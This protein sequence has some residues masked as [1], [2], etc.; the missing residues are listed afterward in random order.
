MMLGA[1]A[2]FSPWWAG[3]WSLAV[4]GLLAIAAA[5]FELVG[6][7]ALRDGGT[8]ERRY[9][10]SVVLLVAGLLLFLS[11]AF[12]LRALLVV[13]AVLLVADGVVK[14]AS[15][16]RR[17]T[18][19]R[20][21]QVV[22]GL[23][24]IALGAFLFSYRFSLG[25]LAVGLVVGLWMISAGWTMAFEQAALEPGTASE[26]DPGLRLGLGPETGL[27]ARASEAL[28]REVDRQNVDF[29]WCAT[30]AATFFAIHIGRM[31]LQFSKFGIISV[32]IAVL[33]D[34][35][36]AV[37]LAVVVILP[38]RLFVRR[39]ARGIERSAWQRRLSDSS[40]SQ[41]LALGD[42]L[43]NYWLDYR[44]RFDARLFTMR[45]SFK[46]ALFR[47]VQIGLP[48][49][50]LLVAVNPLWGI[51]WFFNTEDWVTGFWQTLVEA[52]IDPWRETMIDAV[53][54]SQGA[55]SPATPGL[56]EIRPPGVADATDF[57]FV[58]IG[59]TGEGDDSQLV[60]KD[61]L[62]L[63]GQRDEVKFLVVSSDVIYPAGAMKDYEPNFYLP[64]KGF[65]KPIYAIPGNHDWYMGNA[66]FT[67][68][69]FEVDA[70]RAALRAQIAGDPVLRGRFDERTDWMIAE[71]ERLRGE[72]RVQTGGQRAPFF[73]IHGRDF[74]LITVD[75]GISKR[76]DDKEKAW[77]EAALERS[78]GTFTLVN[79]GHPFYAGGYDQ[80]RFTPSFAAISDI[81][82][83]YDV[84]VVVAGDTHDF[85]YYRET[86]GTKTTHNFVTGGGGAYLSI[87][88]A[89]DW[90]AQPPVADWAYYP[91]A[92]AL[93]HKLDME[94]S[95]W[96]RP[97]WW[98]AKWAGGWPSSVEMLSG[99]FDFNRAPFYQS[100]LEVNVEGSRNQVRIV[101]Q[102]VNG[103]LTW[104]DL[105]R[106]GNI[107]PANRTLDDAVE[108][109]FP[110]HADSA[111]QNNVRP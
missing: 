67:A 73:E 20:V 83:R 95:G 68:N 13:L 45:Q 63:E 59:D 32:T 60:L 15:I 99:A 19:S 22:N 84:P 77:L 105:D 42:R 79:L 10:E 86:S 33:G 4:L 104:R 48:A 81:L 27:K 93:R 36:I 14:L 106:G 43:A 12:V 107:V 1:V 85:E 26:F 111:G 75:T 53:A 57:S 16:A 3:E 11:P 91:S 110:L 82:A 89:L 9:V 88:T 17:G 98:W 2:L 100:F 54:A 5:V 51:S 58:I 78:R 7:R 94:T 101:L 39:V 71:A 70:A 44:L 41:T 30:L 37:V 49:T 65:E 72:Y 80:R 96:K 64:F 76:I 69:F 6:V 25:S 24:H 35:V 31:D 66:A 87:G 52:R 62:M 50:A 92:A 102:G 109:V 23:V 90:P 97:F 55:S 46:A 28:A 56:F 18:D 21:W 74:S 47:L 38:V 108:F 29:A 61:R 40:K 8:T 34:L 103:P